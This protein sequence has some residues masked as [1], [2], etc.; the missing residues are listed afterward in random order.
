MHFG[1][2][3]DG[4]GPRCGVDVDRSLM[5]VF[6]RNCNQELASHVSTH[7]S[8]QETRIRTGKGVIP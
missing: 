2:G 6:G 5:T 7:G 1:R 3:L 4:D 8:L